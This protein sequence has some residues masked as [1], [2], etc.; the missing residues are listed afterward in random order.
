[1]ELL[2]NSSLH[3]KLTISYEKPFQRYTYPMLGSKLGLVKVQIGL[4]NASIIRVIVKRL[5]VNVKNHR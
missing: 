3:N 4:G 5:G 1:M 2:D